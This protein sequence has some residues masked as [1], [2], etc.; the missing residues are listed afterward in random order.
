MRKSW[1]DLLPLLLLLAGVVAHVRGIDSKSELWKRYERATEAKTVPSARLATSKSYQPCI[2]PDSKPGHCRHLSSCPD[3][4]FK[5]NIPRMLQYMCVIE[6]EFVGVCCPDEE[7][8]DSQNDIL[9]VGGLAGSLPAIAIEGDDAVVLPDDDRNSTLARN[10]RAHRGCGVSTHD[11]SRV[12]G[13]RPTSSREYPWIA[14]LL[15]G[16]EQICGG[17]LITDRHILTAAHCVFRNKPRELKVRLGEYDLRFPNETRAIDFRVVEI[18]IHR[19]YVHTT[20]KDDI[21]ILKIHKPTIFNT[22]IW[23]ICLPPVGAVF[24]NKRATVIGWGTTSFAGASSYVLR[25]VMVPIWP[26]DVC[27]GKFTQEITEKN[28]CAGAYEGNGDA[29]QGDSG[30]PL[31]HQLSNGRWISV[32]IVSWGIGCGE[33]DKPGIYTRVN[34]YL[35]WIFA[36][37]VF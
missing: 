27:S 36:N 19:G 3:E 20:Y 28:L 23:P 21:A 1:R 25:E 17:V 15:R 9:P 34:S 7:T 29:C 31:M 35:D 8:E 14:A 22:Y 11:Q 4:S 30:G 13:G 6:K 33:P 12:T 10:S 5:T 37:A 32:G 18:R 16:G 26:Q 2:G 24:E